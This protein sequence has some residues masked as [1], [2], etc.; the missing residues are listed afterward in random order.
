MQEK[1]ELLVSDMRNNTK[2]LRVEDEN[3]SKLNKEYQITKME[4]KIAKNLLISCKNELKPAIIDALKAK[5]TI[6]KY[7]KES[8][9]S[10]NIEQ[11]EIRNIESENQNIRE[12]IDGL[13][14]GENNLTQIKEEVV[15]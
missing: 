15:N 5:K 1:Y 4:L 10:I 6:S 2:Q 13:K 14:A 11:N 3:L 8:Q 7:E 12:K 9:Q